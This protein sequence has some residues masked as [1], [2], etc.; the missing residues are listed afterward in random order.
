M[1]NLRIIVLGI[2]IVSA[3]AIN[4]FQPF[5]NNVVI[6]CNP[7]DPNYNFLTGECDL[8]PSG[9]VPETGDECFV[10]IYD[11]DMGLI[12]VSVGFETICVWAMVGSCTPVSC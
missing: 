2:F 9:E 6:A 1:K 5:K 8:P 11:P 12:P 7:W 10:Y 3:I 4:I